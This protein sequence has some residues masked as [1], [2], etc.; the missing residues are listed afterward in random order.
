[1]YVIRL[2]KCTQWRREKV[3]GVLQTAFTP[4]K[5]RKGGVACLLDFIRKKSQNEVKLNYEYPVFC[6]GPVPGMD[7]GYLFIV[8]S[9]PQCP[10]AKLAACMY[11]TVYVRTCRKAKGRLLP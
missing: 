4:R 8:K 1:M 7:L 5:E 6:R 3:E 2:S 10:R 9:Q 11:A